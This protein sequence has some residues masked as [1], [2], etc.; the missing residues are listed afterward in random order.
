[1]PTKRP[2]TVDDLASYDRAETLFTLNL[3]EITLKNGALAAAEQAIKSLIA[4]YGADAIS[5]STEHSKISVVRPL[6]EEELAEALTRA[7]ETYDL[8]RKWE[9]EREGR[10]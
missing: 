10:S 9:Q 4:A 7:Q 8:L 5:V 6:S 1:M 3:S 2:E